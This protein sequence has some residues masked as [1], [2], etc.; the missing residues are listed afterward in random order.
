M[1]DAVQ[2]LKDNDGNVYAV[3]GGSRCVTLVPESDPENSVLIEKNGFQFGG[4][5]IDSNNNLFIL[6]GVGI[7]ESDIESAKEEDFENLVVVKY[8]LQGNEIKECGI[9]IKTS[10]AQYPFVYGNA[11][12]AVKDN[13]LG[14]F[15]NTER[16]MS[17]DGKN[18]Q[19]SE[20]ATINTETME[21]TDFKPKQ[22]SHSFGVCMLPTDY[23]FA[24]I[25]MGDE[26]PRGINL[27]MYTLSDN[28]INLIVGGCLLF[29]ANGDSLYSYVY[30]HMG[31]LA[32]AKTTYA[33]AGKSK[34]EY[35]SV[36]A[37][38]SL[39]GYDVFVKIIDDSLNENVVGLAGEDRIDKATGKMLVCVNPE[40]FRPAEVELLLLCSLG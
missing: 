28:S 17:S 5:T 29:H 38:S 15:F 1:P 24:A 11:N 27:N 6:W 34:R 37:D 14:C 8:D 20:F 12:L 35:D 36:H 13:I 40:F 39:S 31:G 3:C 9:S 4:S 22:G 26:N 19:C 7:S 10:G 2:E 18:H 23:G 21:L 16:I 30:L 25:Q 33:I 32:K